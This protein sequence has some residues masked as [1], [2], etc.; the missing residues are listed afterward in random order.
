MTL[1]EL[2]VV[3]IPAYQPSAIFTPLVEQLLSEQYPLVLVVD[4][5]SSGECKEVFGK[6]ESFDR[7]VLLRH[8]INLGKGA[9][10]KTAFNYV[11]LNFPKG[12]GVVT[13]D[14]DGQHLSKDV[15][16]VAKELQRVPNCLILGSRQFKENNQIPLRSRIGNQLT[17][18]IFRVLLGKK[19]NDTQTGLRAIPLSFL[20]TLMRLTSTRYEFELDMLIKATDSKIPLLEVP[21]EAIYEGKNESSH[22]N[23]IVDSV[24]I[25]FVFFRFVL[26]SMMTA[27]LDS[28]VFMMAFNLGATILG[29]TVSGRA[30]AGTFNFI[31]SKR[32]VFRSGGPWKTELVKYILL[33]A[34][35]MGASYAWVSALVRGG[36]GILGAKILTETALFFL[37]FS[38][39]R[40][41][42]FTQSRQQTG[43]PQKTDWDAYYNKPASTAHVTRKFTLR[44][45]KE[46]FS[47]YDGRLEEA[48]FLEWGGANSCFYANLRDQLHPK[49]YW[50]H[51]TNDLGLKKFNDA[52]G[53]QN[54]I[55]SKQDVLAYRASENSK[56]A[57]VCFSVGLIEHFMPNE[58]AKAIQAHFESVRKGG[59]VLIT[60]PTPTFL[61]RVVRRALEMLGLWGFPDER[62]LTFD[63]V[64]PEITKYGTIVHSSINWPVILTQG[65]V[66]AKRK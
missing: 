10:L 34:V 27:V 45:L 59:L 48:T 51:D 61:Y 57:D 2:P 5:G 19:L 29:S 4:D 14:A 25:Y 30:V 49:E 46:C 28:I 53:S 15:L 36:M 35:L 22:F 65:V 32:S 66:V 6:L 62:P 63:E 60:F 11:L 38:A 37:S 39:Q 1:T 56:L 44:R 55:G 50:V 23:P 26:L 7:V 8:A 17:K 21:I 52:Y 3:I 18:Q 13:V 40:I 16:S 12:L 41:I 42:V 47:L 33:V 20:P 58:T 64:V 31:Y 54:A 9:A 24:R 43:I